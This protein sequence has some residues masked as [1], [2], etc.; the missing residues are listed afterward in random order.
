MRFFCYVLLS[1]KL[2]KK[3]QFEDKLKEEGSGNCRIILWKLSVGNICHF[4]FIS[5]LLG[6]WHDVRKRWDINIP[7]DDNTLL[8]PVSILITLHSSC[9]RHRVSPGWKVSTE[10]FPS[11]R[12]ITALPYSIELN[13]LRGRENSQ[14]VTD[15]DWQENLL[16]SSASSDPARVREGFI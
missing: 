14:S 3:K 11:E 1:L 15:W 10:K 6:D 2:W 8:L 9:T 5:I 4:L 13:I 16:V 12:S 7:S